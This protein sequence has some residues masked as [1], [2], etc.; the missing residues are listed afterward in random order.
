MT[1][2]KE[3]TAAPGTHPETAARR[4]PP[5]PTARVYEEWPFDAAEAKRRQ[6]ETAS[7]LRIPVQ[8]AI[9]L[10]Q[11]VAIRMVLI[12][13][14]EFEMGSPP[15]EHDRGGDEP[16]H[17]VRITRPFYLG[18]HPVTQEQWQC[19]VGSNPSWFKGDKHPVEQI[20][21]EDC[22]AFV[23]KANQCT[24]KE[25]FALPTE[26]Q[27]EYACRAGKSGRFDFGDSPASLD[28]CAWYSSGLH[29][30]THP[31]GAT[32]PNAWGLY[33]MTDHVGEWCADWYGEAYYECSPQ[34]D[35]GGPEAGRCRVLR[36]GF[37]YPIPRITR[38]ACRRSARPTYRCYDV[39]FRVAASIGGNPGAVGAETPKSP[40]GDPAPARHVPSQPK[41]ESNE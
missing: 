26:A 7:A 13:A 16:L 23:E 4:P 38:F 39:G 29:D 22:Q 2:A 17:R 11:G 37:W 1:H 32:P 40:C 3:Q 9:R 15:W 31:V 24:G 19:V 33:D 35:P 10:G 5:L 30:A 20:S 21:W 41:G 8:K 6:A 34:D 27:W 25:L 18:R 14:G 12:P 36:G 28:K